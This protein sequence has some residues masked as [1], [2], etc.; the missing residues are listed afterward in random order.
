MKKRTISYISIL[1]LIILVGILLVACGSSFTAPASSGG[2]SADGQTLMEQR[3]TVCHSADRVT[4]AQKT[5]AQWKQTVDKMINNGAQL[6]PSEEQTL[7]NYL[8]QTYHP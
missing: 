7:V 3:C 6:S 8:A 1:V 2:S 4:S 5:A